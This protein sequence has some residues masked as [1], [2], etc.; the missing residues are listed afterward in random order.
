MALT[1]KQT[2]TQEQVDKALAELL[3]KFGPGHS[4][5]AGT[6]VLGYIGGAVRDGTL[7][8]DH[9][10]MVRAWERLLRL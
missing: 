1:K 10:A 7:R 2:P 6:F 4:Q 8:S 9:I 3:E 5:D